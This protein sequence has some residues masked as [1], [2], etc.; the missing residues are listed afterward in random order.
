MN[1]SPP[2]VGFLGAFR[3]AEQA[4]VMAITGFNLGT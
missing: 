3:L 1:N 2:K 4:A